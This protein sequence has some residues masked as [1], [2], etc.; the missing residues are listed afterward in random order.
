VPAGWRR[1]AAVESP[2][3]LREHP[4][5]L[6]LTLLAALLYAREREITDALVDLLIRPCIGS[7]RAPRRR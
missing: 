5:A 2:S 7:A 3:H 1:R 6:R 4:R